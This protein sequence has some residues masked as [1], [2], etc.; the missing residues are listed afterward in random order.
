[1]DPM[2]GLCLHYRPETVHYRKSENLWNNF[3]SIITLDIDTFFI[4]KIENIK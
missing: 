3:P 2:S 4:S 1:M